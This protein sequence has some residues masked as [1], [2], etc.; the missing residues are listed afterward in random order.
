M[1]VANRNVNRR[2]RPSRD[3]SGAKG[4]ADLA[5]SSMYLSKVFSKALMVSSFWFLVSGSQ[6]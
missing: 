6:T 5:V 3:Q 1:D 4:P 2:S